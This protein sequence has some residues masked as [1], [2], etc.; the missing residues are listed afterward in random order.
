[1][2]YRKK[3][4]QR[5]K[6]GKRGGRETKKLPKAVPRAAADFVQQQKIEKLIASKIAQKCAK[7]LA[8]LC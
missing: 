5:T 3:R 7:F 6:V 8:A 2:K 1:M 4:R